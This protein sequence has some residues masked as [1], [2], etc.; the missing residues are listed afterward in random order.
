MKTTENT[1]IK[2]FPK[3]LAVYFSLIF[4]VPIVAAWLILNF[5]RVLKFGEAVKALFMPIPL[6]T[7][8]IGVVYLVFILLPFA[9]FCHFQCSG[10]SHL[11]LNLFLSILFFDAITNVFKIFH[12]AIFNC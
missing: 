12:L 9:T 11:L 7:I 2:P 3:K 4:A 8:A 1:I 10:L 6:I 5:L